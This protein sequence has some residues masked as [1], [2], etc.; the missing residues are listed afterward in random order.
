MDTEI[1]TS[2]IDSSTSEQMS[3]R[4]SRVAALLSLCECNARMRD[5]L[6]LQLTRRQA[7]AHVFSLGFG[8]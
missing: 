1:N 7:G 6:Q 4:R 8:A 5:P 3:C 2:L